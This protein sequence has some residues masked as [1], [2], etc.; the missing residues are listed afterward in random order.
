[1]LHLKFRPYPLTMILL[2][3]LPCYMRMWPSN[4]ETTPEEHPE[5]VLSSPHPPRDATGREGRE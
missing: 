4:R 3:S 2:G 1:M 5:S